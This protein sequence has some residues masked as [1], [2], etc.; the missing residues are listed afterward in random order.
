[1]IQTLLV[2]LMSI[3]LLLYS[4]RGR[5][6]IFI[7]FLRAK[8]MFIVSIETMG[9][10]ITIPRFVCNIEVLI[11]QALPSGFVLLYCIQTSGVG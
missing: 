7:Q 6:Q 3:C 9:Q 8:N 2:G 1:M 11:P 4:S 10:K 5:G